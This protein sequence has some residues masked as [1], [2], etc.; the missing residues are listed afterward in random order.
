MTKKDSPK[1]TARDESANIPVTIVREK[2]IILA[3][4]IKQII[5]KKR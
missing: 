4:K 1:Y 5:F 2:K 3:P